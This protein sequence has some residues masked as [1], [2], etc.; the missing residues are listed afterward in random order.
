MCVCVWRRVLVPLAERLG[1]DSEGR[2]FSLPLKVPC[3]LWFLLT[4]RLACGANVLVFK[5]YSNPFVLQA[6]FLEK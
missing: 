2:Y 5:L 4:P 6:V 1:K 3:A